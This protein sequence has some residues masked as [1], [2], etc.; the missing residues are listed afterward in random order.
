MV[1]LLVIF[2]DVVPPWPLLMALHLYYEM[3]G[4]FV[5]IKMLF[6]DLSNYIDD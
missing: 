6:H 2:F 3:E 1:I 5:L 4:I